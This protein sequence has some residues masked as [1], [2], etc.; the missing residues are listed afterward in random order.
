MFDETAPA[1]AYIFV[2]DD[3]L[4][5]GRSVRSSLRRSPIRGGS[6]L[7]TAVAVQQ[8]VGWPNERSF[9]RF[10]VGVPTHQ[11]PNVSA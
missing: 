9:T 1:A 11:G 3:G 10:P 7:G 5:V 4:S 8:L 2:G 6:D